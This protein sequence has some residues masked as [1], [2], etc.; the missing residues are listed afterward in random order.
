MRIAVLSRSSDPLFYGIAEEQGEAI[1][2]AQ[3]SLQK[4]LDVHTNFS[5][6]NYL[7]AVI[8]RD[9]LMFKYKKK[10]KVKK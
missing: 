5:V 9:E 4:Y 7:L 3:K 6:D 8:K 10:V 2:Q 1:A